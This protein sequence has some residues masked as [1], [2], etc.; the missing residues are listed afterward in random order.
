MPSWKS[1]RFH[2]R[3]GVIESL[4]D[5]TAFMNITFLDPLHESLPARSERLVA[6]LAAE[7]RSY[8]IPIYFLQSTLPRIGGK[9]AVFSQ[10]EHEIGVGFL[11]PRHIDSDSVRH[12]TLRYHALTNAALP[13]DS[14]LLTVTNAALT[15]EQV[16]IYH[17]AADHHFAQTNHAFGTVE[18]GRPS[19]SE[20][21]LI[22][23][24][25]QQVWDA[26]SD[27]C[28]PADIHSIEFALGTSLVARVEGQTVGFLFGATKFGGYSLPMDW[29][30]R[31]NGD[32]RLE[33]QVMGVLA[34]FRGLRIANLLKRQQA[35]DAID[36]GIG[37]VNWTADPLQYA[38]AA[39]NFG[40]LHAVAFDFIPN[41]YT[42]R[43]ALNRVPASRFGLTWLVQS[44]RVQQALALD[45]RSSVI[46]LAQHPEIVRVND[47][48]HSTV[49][50][51]NSPLIAIEIPANW[52]ALQRD[53]LDEAL[54]WRET[55]D[56]LFARYIGKEEDKYV[57]TGVGV[58][59]EQR[60]LIGERSGSALW[61]RLAE[62]SIRG[63]T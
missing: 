20:A 8:L 44:K 5:L 37:I 12:Y 2:P 30:Q 16:V 1:P 38:N 17:P 46:N 42:F 41:L 13:S 24:L 6:H 45:A 25:Q 27:E 29:Q 33:S 19:R 54:H 51:T 50:H 40:L 55:T 53:N 60:Y 61:R 22:P 10:G 52:T 7:S 26:A 31:F 49:N 14:E 9:I 34:H 39:L 62:V 36:A 35:L 28:Y 48:W 63:K 56:Q 59:G 18:I 3:L 47:G 57:I 58:D 43:N 21:A 32:M 15:S 11:F 23:Q 4:I